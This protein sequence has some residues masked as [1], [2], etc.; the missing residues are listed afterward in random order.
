[1]ARKITL[2]NF[3]ADFL[4]LE[5]EY[6]DSD[7]LKY[8]NEFKK[9]K[10]YLDSNN[11]YLNKL[12]IHD[13][14]RIKELQIN[15]EKDLTVFVG[16]N[17]FGK[18]SIL[19]AIATALSWLRSNIEKENKPGRYIKNNEINNSEEVEYSSIYANLKIKDYNTSV[20]I[21]RSK[22]GTQ[23]SRNNELSEIKKLASIY[24]L[25]NKFS[26]DSNL[27][28]M[29]YYSI[30][31]SYEG[32]GVD[33]KR[34]KTNVKSSWSKFDVYDEMEF[35]RNDFTDFFQWLIFLYNRTSHEKLNTSH[36]IFNDLTLDIKRLQET[37]IQLSKMSD[38]DVSLIKGI[39]NSIEEK[40]IYLNNIKS[41]NLTSNKNI[42][43]YDKVIE[44][45]LIFLPE[46]QEIKIYYGNSDYK[47]LLR[48]GNSL[49]DI[50]QLSQGE[51]T[52][53]TLVGDLAR[54]LILL[55]PNSDAP[56]EGFGI[57]LIDEIDLHLHP[58]WQQTI[59]RRLTSTF[60]NVQFIVTTHSPQILSTVN[61]RSVRILQECNRD[62]LEELSVSFPDYQTKGVSNQDALLYGMK[63]DPI[64]STDE[65]LQ[66]ESY[67]KLIEK[68]Q[69]SS[70][71]ALY[72]REKLLRHF[73]E[74]HPLIQ[75]CDDLIS[76]LKFKERIKTLKT[77]KSGGIE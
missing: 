6:D 30:N 51:K 52:I 68:N 12:G 26:D 57:V 24:R 46:F 75:E 5:S 31:R 1:M 11:F 65:Y 69:Y 27:P 64:P 71:N 33:N 77:N 34:K 38:I 40:K 23:Y 56:F 73:G 67:K 36:E 25:V 76:V 7:R 20:L 42:S 3:Y 18:S 54:R 66:L 39:N 8:S 63:T 14:K 17:G 60:P 29:A 9:I 13:F 45:I 49:L 41:K 72:L 48:K 44:T 22:E 59:I 53:F 16:D 58:Q 19:E 61:S 21:T 10:S 28:L 15:L 37:L 32:G 4:R 2:D 43:L 50:Q 47:L 35:D 62:G 70:D 55:N 74:E